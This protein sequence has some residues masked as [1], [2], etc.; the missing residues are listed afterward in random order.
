[1]SH[2]VEIQA[3]NIKKFNYMRLGNYHD[4][5]GKLVKYIDINGVDLGG[6]DMTAPIVHLNIEEEHQN[7][8][9]EFIQGHPFVAQKKLIVKD[10]YANRKNSAKRLLKSADCV[11]KATQMNDEQTKEF[12]VL[13]GLDSKQDIDLQKAQLI[14][15]ASTQP[16]KFLTILDDK[17]NPIK[18][19]VK[20]ALAKG[21]IKRVNGTYKYNK[22]TIGLTE[23]QAMHW[24]KENQDV[25][26][27]LRKQARDAEK[28]KVTKKAKV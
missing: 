20:D 19:F 1:M 14:Q 22:Q 9:W 10:L 27:L 8:L 28:P 13:A 16:E 2:L 25:Y 3:R 24:F 6:W 7:K 21:V 12:M 18:M 11:Q 26:A 5:Y 17:D 23:D 4:K 15:F